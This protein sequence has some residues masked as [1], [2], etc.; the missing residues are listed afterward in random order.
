MV[1]ERLTFLVN[2]FSFVMRI[3]MRSQRFQEGLTFAV[4][5]NP[6]NYEILNDELK[7]LKDIRALR[8]N[9]GLPELVMPSFKR[10]MEK[11]APAFEKI[12]PTLFQEF[13][14]T[15]ECGILL[16]NNNETFIYGFGDR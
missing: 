10:V 5:R 6:I 15:N 1:R 16:I 13:S 12:M 7:H 14:A 8:P 2:M 4:P 11:S 9:W 3:L